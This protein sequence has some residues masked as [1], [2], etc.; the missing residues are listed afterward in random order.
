MKPTVSVIIPTYN[1]AHYLTECVNSVLT[2][3]SPVDEILVVDDGSTDSTRELVS[4]WKGRVTYLS[5]RNAGAAAA[6]NLGLRA[7]SGDL[8]AFQDSDDLWLPEKNALQLD[9]FRCHPEV[10]VVFGLMA[11]FED[12]QDE[13]TAEI[14]DR[15]VYELLRATHTHVTDMFSLLLRHNMVPTPTVM[16]R[17]SCVD[18]AG[19]FDANLRISEDFEYWL[20]MSSVCRFAFMDRVLLRRRRHDSN[21]INDRQTRLRCRISILQSMADRFPQLTAEQ[22]SGLDRQ[23]AGLHYDLGSLYLREGRFA[24]ASEHLERCRK[25]NHSPIAWAKRLVASGLGLIQ[26]GAGN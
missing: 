20:R 16:F 9:F 3:T 13:L 6:R 5:Q 19:L 7:A 8:V 26:K 21:L 11:N 22:L 10:E 2:Q 15:A 14:G 23:L 25:A 4:E 12:E 18:K 1:R 24:A 17:R